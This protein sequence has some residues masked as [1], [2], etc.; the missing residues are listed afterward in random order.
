MSNRDGGKL[1]MISFKE[2]YININKNWKFIERDFDDIYKIDGESVNLWMDIDLPHDWSIYKDFNIN[3]K[4]RN[5]AGLL[6]GG[7]A[8]YAKTLTLSDKDLEKEIHIR[9]GGVYMDSTIW[10]N[11]KYIGSYP[12]G[13]TEFIYEISDYLHVGNNLLLIRVANIQ[14]SSRWYSG[15]GIYRNVDLIIKDKLNFKEDSIVIKTINLKEAR[16]SEVK[17]DVSFT[18]VNSNRRKMKFDIKYFVIDDSG[19]N[20]SNAFYIRDLVV[21][22]RENKRIHDQFSLFN[23]KLWSVSSPSCYYLCS[24]IYSDRKLVD[25]QITRFGYR[26]IDWDKDEGIYLNGEYIKLHGVCLHH[27]NGALG[28][29]LYSDADRRKLAI[30]K[31]MGANAIR[32]SHNPQSREFIELCDKMGFLVIEEAFDTW[33]GLPKK[34]YDYN[35]FFL[36]K[37]SHPDVENGETWGE[38]DLK[39][40]VRRDINSPSIIMWS[41]GNEI[42]ESKENYGPQ[43]ADL[44]IKACKE[45]DDSRFVTMGEDGFRNVGIDDGSHMEIANKLDA[46]GINYGEDQIESIRKLYPNWK[47]YGSE[48]SS[49]LRSR[50]VYYRPDLKDIAHDSKIDED[51]RK[52]QMSDYGNDRVAWGKTAIDSWII[53]RD[54]KAYAGQFVWT[55]FDYIGEPTPWHNMEDVGAPC[56]SSYFGLVDTCG[57]PKNDYYFYQSQWVDKDDKAMVKVLPHWD[58]DNRDR[59]EEL[60]TY[61]ESED[62]V[63][64]V[65]SNLKNVELKL[66]G[67]SLGI[68]SFNE[69]MTD[70][71]AKYLEGETFD[72]LYLQWL[73]PFERGRLEAFAFEGCK[74][75]YDK[76]E[77]SN[78]PIAIKLQLDNRSTC[79]DLVF[80]KFSITDE[81]GRLVNY[82]DN[83]VSFQVD[84]G[85][86][87]G[88]DNGNPASQ[89]RYKS[90]ADLIWVRKAFNGSGLVI[91]KPD[92][93]DCTLHAYSRNLK[94]ARL[95]ID[96]GGNCEKI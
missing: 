79:E 16:P 72:Q 52:Y 64:R 86:I 87:I 14:P 46:V 26:Y 19:K 1:I 4:A 45:I 78:G 25:E 91:V 84:N 24:Q 73:V 44:L 40:M 7:V 41:I 5:E 94:E 35:R 22:Q 42:Y 50:G 58:F 11:G 77:T 39:Q 33:S 66:N 38:F 9:F 18:V 57:F 30:M 56:K 21:D 59:L 6:D 53:D 32:T 36:E 20:V 34:N 27:D 49:A 95:S 8:F 93:C 55:G 63:V 47:I 37:A 85:E 71:G 92:S 43:I 51:I 90:Y 2:K 76:A 10:L 65:Y 15:S 31:D 89:E 62:I 96:I 60:G 13:Y 80:V 12:S 54:N 29:E 48:T 69:K 68:K 17:S 75:A 67:K 82:A 3:S 88:V 28:S 23:P 61:I 70:Y 83:L 81:E 74:S